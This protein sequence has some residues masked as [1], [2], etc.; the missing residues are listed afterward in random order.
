MK[1]TLDLDAELEFPI[2]LH[3]ENGTSVKSY[4][5]AALI[6]YRDMLVKERDGSM[7]GFGDRKRFDT[8]N[9]EASPL[10]YLRTAEDT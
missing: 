4:I 5:R 9:T 1:V 7:V 2:K 3:L 10:T 8:Y 6:F